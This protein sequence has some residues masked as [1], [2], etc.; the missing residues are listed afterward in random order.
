ME[1][2]LMG[3]RIIHEAGIY[4]IDGA[5]MIYTIEIVQLEPDLE[6]KILARFAIHK[7]I[8]PRRHK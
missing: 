1:N 7:S 8:Y 3:C 4:L 6:F 5:D 2:P